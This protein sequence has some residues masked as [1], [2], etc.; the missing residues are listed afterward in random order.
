LKPDLAQPDL[1]SNS[2]W[3][4]RTPATGGCPAEGSPRPGILSY[5]ILYYGQALRAL[6]GAKYL[7]Y[8]IIFG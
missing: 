3:D 5:P 4:R 8:T 1:V 2:T 7:F 6:L